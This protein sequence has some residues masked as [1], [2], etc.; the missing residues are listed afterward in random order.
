M[1][2]EFITFTGLDE[3]VDMVRL[4]DLS[5][6]FPVE[7]G[8]LFSKDR[9]GKEKR[10]PAMQFVE[11][12]FLGNGLRLSAHICGSYSR[13]IVNGTGA[14]IAGFLD[15]NFERAQ[16]N[17]GAIPNNGEYW[18]A[19]FAESIQAKSAILQTRDR[20]TT[21]DEVDWL[22]DASGGRG[23]SPKA[24]PGA[25]QLNPAFC[26]Y[27]GGIGPHN[28]KEVLKQINAVH[29]PGKP[30][31]IDMEG[32]IRTHDFLDLDKCEAVLKSVYPTPTMPE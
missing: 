26:G 27:A 1:R 15:G 32:Q 30:F 5:A 10:F 2:P 3:S 22:F 7:W 8:I 4:R 16:L 21:T 28:V 24:W 13:S 25:S 20:F 23:E 14:E 11:H 9:T 31:W 18:A 19:R 17:V 6:R 12:F 29:L